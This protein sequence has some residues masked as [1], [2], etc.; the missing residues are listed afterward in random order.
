[1]GQ[2]SFLPW[3]NNLDESQTL[4]LFNNSLYEVLQDTNLGSGEAPVSAIGFNISCGYLPYNV[5]QALG[6]TGAFFEA[7]GECSVH[8]KDQY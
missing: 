4:G 3:I 1:V 6:I 8:A 7:S 5:T 2:N